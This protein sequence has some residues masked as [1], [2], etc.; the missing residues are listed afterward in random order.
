M[1]HDIGNDSGLLGIFKWH[2]RRTPETAK[3]SSQLIAKHIG[4]IGAS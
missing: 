3:S 2:P 1:D 4:L